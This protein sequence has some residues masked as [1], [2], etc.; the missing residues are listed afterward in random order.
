MHDLVK[1]DPRVF[2]AQ[3][4]VHPD[5]L[6]FGRTAV[7]KPVLAYN[8]GRPCIRDMTVKNCVQ[9]CLVRQKYLENAN[10]SYTLSMPRTVY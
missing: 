3:Q 4:H 1:W 2:S 7:E 10:E 5:G 9:C 6:T 8:R